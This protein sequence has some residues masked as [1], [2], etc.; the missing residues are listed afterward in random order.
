MSIVPWDVLA[1]LKYNKHFQQLLIR[2]IARSFFFCIEAFNKN[3]N[4]RLLFVSRAVIFCSK[5]VGVWIIAIVQQP[6]RTCRT[7]AVQKDQKIC[8][9]LLFSHYVLSPGLVSLHLQCKSSLQY[10]F[11]KTPKYLFLSHWL[12]TEA[13]DACSFFL[14]GSFYWPIRVWNWC[15]VPHTWYWQ[16]AQITI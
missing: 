16:R 7:N 15:Y 4:R 10:L 1:S 13:F 11:A 6:P 9:V 14:V 8:L 2:F 12:N 3:V 5:N